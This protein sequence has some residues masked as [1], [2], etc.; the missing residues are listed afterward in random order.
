MLADCGCGEKWVNLENLVRGKS[1]ACLSCPKN[2]SQIP[3]QIYRKLA[4]RYDAI[5]Q[6]CYQKT[7][8][9]YPL[10]GGRGIY[11]YT[12]WMGQTQKFVDYIYNLPGFDITKQ[13]DRIDNDRG[14]EPGNLRWATPSENMRNT[15]NTYRITIDGQ[16]VCLKD[17]V[18]DYTWISYRFARKYISEGGKVE[19]LPLL[20]P[21]DKSPWYKS[22][23]SG[24]LRPKPPFQT[25]EWISGT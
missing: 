6:R 1:T 8:P 24:E 15:S 11:L 10:Y 23:R 3:K 25:C 17:Y 4:R 18:K 14:Y 16:E 20:P 5:I 7:C 22:F 21:G 2:K 12:E 19:D 13:L 9:S